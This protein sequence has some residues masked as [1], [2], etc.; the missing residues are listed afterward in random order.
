[1]WSSARIMTF[2]SYFQL[3]QLMKR[4][5]HELNHSSSTSEQSI[6]ACSF[7]ILVGSCRIG[8]KQQGPLLKHLSF[9]KRDVL[10]ACPYHP[11]KN[12]MF[13][14]C[15]A[16]F[17][18][19][20]TPKLLPFDTACISGSCYR[21]LQSCDSNNIGFKRRKF[22]YFFLSHFSDRFRNEGKAKANTVT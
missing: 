20:T 6:M 14:R 21:V 16:A 3:Q 2:L 9:Q 15:L 1:M 13:C 22:A 19:F 11:Q 17:F 10:K 5:W 7:L 4:P 18:I 12:V 8:Y